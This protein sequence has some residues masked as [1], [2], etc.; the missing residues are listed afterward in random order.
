LENVRIRERW[1]LSSSRKS[2]L[3]RLAWCRQA[4]SL[5]SAASDESGEGGSPDRKRA[6]S[7]GEAISAL[8]AGEIDNARRL[9]SRAANLIFVL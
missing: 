6:V 5:V 2:E 7:S 9:R 3:K 4:G 8:R 1:V